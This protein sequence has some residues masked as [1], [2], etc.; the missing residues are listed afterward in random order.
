MVNKESLNGFIESDINKDV[1]GSDHVPIECL[2]DLQK[3]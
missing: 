2:I 3:L 1:K